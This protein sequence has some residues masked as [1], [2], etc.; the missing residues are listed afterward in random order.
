MLPHPYDKK[1]L[2]AWYLYKLIRIPIRLT[3]IS[4]T[5]VKMTIW[6]MI[7][8]LVTTEKVITKPQKLL[9]MIQKSI[10]HA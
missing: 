10:L 9:I 2:T 3:G 4:K 1:C 7:N 5:P 8:H 6:G